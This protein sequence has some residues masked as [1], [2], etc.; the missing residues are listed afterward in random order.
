MTTLLDFLASHPIDNLS[1][2]LVLSQRLKDFKFKIRAMTSSELESYTQQC[3][4]V[5]KGGKAVFNNERFSML[6]LLNHTLEPDFRDV[7]ALEK[8]GCTSPQEFV[9]K[10]LMAG[11]ITQLVNEI[12]QLSGFG[13]DVNELVDEVKNS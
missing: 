4:K 5:E 10:V 3:R 13:Q 8:V 9:N 12:S 7:R 2:E 1:K 11:E 6:V